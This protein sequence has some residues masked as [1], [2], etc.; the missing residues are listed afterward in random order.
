MRVELTP[1]PWAVR[2]WSDL[3]DWRKA[4]IPVADLQPFDIPDDAYFEYA[5]EDGDGE[6]RPDP[7]NPNPLLNPWWKFASHLTGPDYA[8]DPWVVGEGVRPRGR[9]LRMRVPS[10]HFD[11]ARQVLVY[12]PAGETGSR[13]PAVWFQDGKAYFGWGR[14]AQVLDRLLAAGEVAPAHLVFV[15]PNQRTREYAFNPAYL[16]HLVDEVRPA[17]EARIACDGRRIAWGASL[18][19][20]CSALLAWEHPELFGQ[21]VSQSGAFL[22]SPDMDFEFPFE[23]NETFRRRVEVEPAR[24]LRWHLDCG[25]LEWLAGSNARLAAALRASGADVTATTRSAGHN[26]INW[27][28]GLADGLRFALGTG[29]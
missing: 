4:P 5:W 14:V 20:L 16:A 21:V 7:E 23:G 9:V 28:N 17:V 29:R 27:R 25:T 11:T 26:W 22:F 19:G 3:T 13:L 1:P 10:D 24:P 15:T 12:S 6:K 8:P 18:G 2:L